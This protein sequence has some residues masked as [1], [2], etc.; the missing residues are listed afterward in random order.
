MNDQFNFVGD[1]LD[2]NLFNEQPDY[3]FTRFNTG[4]DIVPYLRKIATK[5]KKPVTLFRAKCHGWY[6]NALSKLLFK[7]TNIDQSLIP[8]PLQL[9]SDKSVGWIDFVVLA[10]RAPSLEACLL[11][12]IFQL[13]LFIQP[14]LS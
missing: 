7:S 2:D 11:K 10:M 3:L 14:F 13:S 4:S 8:T 6:H 5:L 12:R 9:G 1:D